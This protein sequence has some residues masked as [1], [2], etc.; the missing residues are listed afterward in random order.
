MSCLEA[1]VVPWILDVNSKA[2]L[3]RF[4]EAVRRLTFARWAVKTAC[5]IDKAGGLGEIPASIPF[6]LFR[7]QDRVPEN[8][9][10]FVGF[11][12]W[13]Q[14]TLLT[15]NQRNRWTHYPLDQICRDASCKPDG[16]FFKVAFAVER[17][18]VLVAAVPSRHFEHV[19]GRGVHVPIWPS[20]E[21]KC[22]HW[23]YSMRIEGCGADEALQNFSDLFAVS[24]GGRM[25]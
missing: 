18:M 17:L 5:I 10:V 11:H 13:A 23:F 9:T 1:A 7:G 15:F 3:L 21:V 12:D 2:D 25:R 22:C 8:V 20:L 19:I 14:S 24:H 6:E 16:V 4:R